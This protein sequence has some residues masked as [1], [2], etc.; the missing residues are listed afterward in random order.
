VRSYTYVDDMVDG[1]FRLM[2]SG[3][4]GAV[5]IGCP[6]YVT[7]NELVA[8]VA[9]VAGKRV[10]VRHVQ[11]PVGVRSRNF[12]N[13]R[14]HSIGWQARTFLEEGIGNT[15]PWIAEQVRK[16]RAAPA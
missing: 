2:H 1:I 16:A 15:Y 10:A 3:L 8:T 5:N 11:G 9:K 7:V 12:S 4:E 6:Q 14:I 13:D